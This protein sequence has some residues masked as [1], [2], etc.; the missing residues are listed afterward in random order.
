MIANPLSDTYSG[1]PLNSDETLVNKAIDGD[2][3]TLNQLIKNHQQYI[4]NIAL[5]MIGDPEEAKD[6]TQE[7]L[8]KIITKLSTFEK[9]SSF[10]TWAYRIVVNHFLNIKK[11]LNE[12]KHKNNFAEYWTVI[13]NVQDFDIP[14]SYAAPVDINLITDEI[15]VSCMFGMLLCLDR[16]QR[17]VYT[18]GV[19]FDV[20]DKVGS[21]LLEISKD[22]FRQKLSRA[23]KDIRN[24]MQDKCG[25]VNPDNPC[26]CRKKTKVLIDSGFVDPKNLKF[27]N[28]K[29][30]SIQNILNEKGEDLNTLLSDK[31]ESLFR[32]HPFQTSPD[33]VAGLKEIIS[34]DK[35]KNIFNFN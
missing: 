8:I 11:T 5:R 23:R 7:V 26:H 4:Y 35:F 12:A 1:E 32:E 15:K 29:Y 16:E 34:S 3:A 13:N 18:L 31:A 33:F 20:T 25:L 19:I 14:D 9:R 21:E 28:E 10:R 24:F 17:M 22:N 30:F 27:N 6:I 2:K